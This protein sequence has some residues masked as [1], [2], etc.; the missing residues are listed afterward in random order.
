MSQPIKL[1]WHDPLACLAHVAA[2]G[3]DYALLYSGMRTDYGGRYSLLAIRPEQT[4]S[5]ADFAALAPVLSTNLPA[6]A[7]AW[8]GYLGY[9][10]KNAVER[11]SEDDPSAIDLPNLHFSRYAS[12]LVFD[13]EERH[14]TLHG[15]ELIPDF[16]QPSPALAPL[17]GITALESDMTRASYLD[18]VQVILDAIR[19]GS[20]YQANLTRKFHGSFAQAPD[21]AAL[22]LRLAEVSPAPYSALIK[23]GDTAIVSSSPEQFLRMDADGRVETRPIKGSARRSADP[24][25]DTAIREALA[26]SEKDQAE[27][28][29]IVDLMRNDLSRSCEIGT[30]RTESLFD[31]STYATVHHMASTVTGLRRSD[32]TPLELVAQ[33]FPPGS[34]T[35]APKIRAMELCSALE[36]RARGIYS[37]AIGWFGGDGSVDLSVVI[38]TLVVQGE[39]FEFQ[40]GGAIVHDSTP[41]GEWEETLV[42][43]RGISLALGIEEEKLRRL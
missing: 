39:R 24:A 40:V 20:L 35:G 5:G 34:M 6:F 38:R 9:G 28:L 21:A 26:T 22:F 41:E 27:N 8:L 31:I 18:K 7:N 11:L 37:G 42:K 2:A 30:V 19:A 10:L 1:D 4:V 13:H 43:A 36:P 32:V 23:W 12:I 33:C 16:G 3:E 29:M 15:E 14:I 17:S 25:E